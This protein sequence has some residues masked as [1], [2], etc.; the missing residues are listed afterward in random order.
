[1]LVTLIMLVKGTKTN[2]IYLGYVVVTQA[3]LKDNGNILNL[4]I[5]T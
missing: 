4:N 5:T 1:M 2:N 3:G